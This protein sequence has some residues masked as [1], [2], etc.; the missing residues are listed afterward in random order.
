MR[1]LVLYLVPCSSSGACSLR[2]LPCRRFPW[3]FSA[4]SVTG[5]LSFCCPGGV[6]WA[7]TLP[8]FFLCFS[9]SGWLAGVRW[10]LHPVSR[11]SSWGCVCSLGNSVIT[12]LA[13]PYLRVGE[14]LACG[15]YG[16][17]Q[18][19]SL[20][21]RLPFVVRPPFHVCLSFTCSWVGV[22]WSQVCG[23]TCSSCVL[24]SSGVS[25]A[26]FCRLRLW[27]HPLLLFSRLGFLPWAFVRTWV[28]RLRS[29]LG[30]YLLLGALSFPCPGFRWAVPAV[31]LSRRQVFFWNLY[32]GSFLLLPVFA[33]G[34]GWLR[35][36]LGYP[37]SV[38]W[39]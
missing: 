28:G 29:C 16:V 3:G 35:L 10:V 21:S 1:R 24:G 15:V 34:L 8:F 27:P 31:W 14:L 36:I 2:S 38:A 25:V 22:V 33:D 13:F 12:L 6:G 5:C 26:P 11:C 23:P 30:S 37:P 39:Q 9:C 19:R 7:A 17:S 20:Q 32:L 18:L 4:F